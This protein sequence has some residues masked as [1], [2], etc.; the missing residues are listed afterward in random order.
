MFII[1]ESPDVSIS[2]HIL[3]RTGQNRRLGG[4][5]E[6]LASLFRQCHMYEVPLIHVCTMALRSDG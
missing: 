3:V 4:M 6:R 1:D 2:C 5:D